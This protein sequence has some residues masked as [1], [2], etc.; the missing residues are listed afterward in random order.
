MPGNEGART[1]SDIARRAGVS[2]MTVSLAL[3]GHPHASAATRDRLRILAEE[4]GYRPNPLV[5]AAMTQVRTG[6]RP[7]FLGTIAFLSLKSS[8]TPE[9]VDTQI[10]RTFL[11][12]RQHAGVLGYRVEWFQLGVDAPNGRRAGD[13]LAARGISGVILG[14]E[15]VLPLQHHLDWSRF[16]IAAFGRS[17]IGRE[18]HRSSGDYYGAIREA[19]E[20]C[21][22]GAYRRIGLALSLEHHIAHQHLH[23]S[24]FLGC[25]A[26]WPARD[27]VPVFLPKRWEQDFFLTWVRRYRP[28]VVIACFDD[29]I[30]WLHSAGYQMPK[31]I[32]LIRPHLYNPDE[33]ISGFL[34]DDA[35]LGAAAVDLV[36]EQLNHNE[37]GLPRAV[38]RVLVPGR[39]FQ[40]RTLRAPTAPGAESPG[41]KDIEPGN[42]RRDPARLVSARA[43][44]GTGTG[45]DCF[46]TA[47]RRA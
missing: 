44:S 46:T 45:K 35:L 41:H 24:A 39:W 32:G 10:Q 27:R 15:Q 36:V 11:G 40:G 5:S 3:R 9:Q 18:L 25:Q 30:R 17:E 33:G 37:R 31:D 23:R 22:M 20:R 19:C 2:K 47:D 28:D 8:P 38:K 26:D 13:I 42:Q 43:T 6:R 1:L 7:S 14:V 16:A 29:P 12:A 34:F 4:M 21:R